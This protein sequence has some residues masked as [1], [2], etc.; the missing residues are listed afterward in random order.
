MLVCNVM[1]PKTLLIVDTE[2]TGLNPPQSSVIELG[3]ILYSVEH[4]CV[5]QQMSTLLPVCGDNLA[6]KINKISAEA[7]RADY[8]V[9]LALALFQQW[10]NCAD[11]LVA[12]NAEFDRQWFGYESLPVVA[13]PWLCTYD[14]FSWAKVSKPGLSLVNLALEHGIGVSSAH[15]ALTDCQLIAALFDRVE[16]F[17]AL[18]SKAI[19]RSQEPKVYVV[20]QVNYED[21]HL[22]KAKGFRWN[23]L[24]QKK[25]A[26]NIRESEL[27][28]ESAAE[29]LP[30][31]VTIVPIT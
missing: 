25:W 12:H 30:F 28:E 31:E 5:L 1:L 9:S 10:L 16:N 22:A 29:L 26:K 4:R 14:D 20:A 21:R 13:K 23:Q 7:S 27:R 3:A 2:T 19:A 18:L 24:V 15:R 11:Y 8:E 17:E 6:Q